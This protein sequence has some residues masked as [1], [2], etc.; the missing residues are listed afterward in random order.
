MPPR[1][2]RCELICNA[3]LPLF[4][5]RCRLGPRPPRN[6]LARHYGGRPCGTPHVPSCLWTHR[7]PM[8]CPY[9]GI[10]VEN[11]TLGLSEPLQ[12]SHDEV[13]CCTHSSPIASTV[14][15]FSFR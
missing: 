5:S 8:R 10:Y 6:A 12:P 14:D 9:A 1:A 4:G 13:R 11:P 15:S 2:N 7:L 3:A